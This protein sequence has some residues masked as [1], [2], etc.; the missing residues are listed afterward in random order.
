[1]NTDQHG[2]SFMWVFVLAG[3]SV[4]FAICVRGCTC[5]I[6]KDIV[7]VTNRATTKSDTA[8]VTSTTREKKSVQIRVHPCPI[9]CDVFAHLRL[10]DF[11]FF[12]PVPS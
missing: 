9:L 1:M 2:F 6:Q 10:S 11:A 3:L 7:Q 12:S 4:E 5:P 8:P